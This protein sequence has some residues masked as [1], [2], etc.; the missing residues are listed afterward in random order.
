M[1]LLW[2]F[3]WDFSL[4]GSWGPLLLPNAWRAFLEWQQWRSAQSTTAGAPETEDLV[5]NHFLRQNP[6]IWTPWHV[7]YG[8]VLLTV[9]YCIY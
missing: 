1:A 7:R 9:L 2:L 4:I 5:T 8:T 6:N 3:M